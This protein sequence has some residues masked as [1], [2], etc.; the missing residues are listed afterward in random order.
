M[1]ISSSVRSS[2]RSP[3]GS[4]NVTESPQSSWTITKLQKELRQRNLSPVGRKAELVERLKVAVKEHGQSESSSSSNSL[5]SSPSKNRSTRNHQRAPESP[6]LKVLNSTKDTLTNSPL[7]KR[8][9]Q[10]VSEGFSSS[11]SSPSRSSSQRFPK[12]SSMVSN[13]L[14]FPLKTLFPMLFTDFSQIFSFVF[15]QFKEIV[16]FPVYFL[17]LLSGPK[18]NSFKKFSFSTLLEKEFLRRLTMFLTFMFSVFLFTVTFVPLNR[19]SK[20]PAMSNLVSNTQLAF[21][22]YRDCLVSGFYY[23]AI[24]AEHYLLSKRFVFLQSSFNLQSFVSKYL[25]TLQS[26]RGGLRDVPLWGPKALTCTF[27]GSNFLSHDRTPINWWFVV[28]NLSPALLA[29]SLGLSF[30]LFLVFVITNWTLYWAVREAREIGG[31][32]GRLPSW[33]LLARIMKFRNKRNGYFEMLLVALSCAFVPS[34]FAAL[35]CM[36]F[37]LFFELSNGQFFFSAL[38]GSFLFRSIAQSGLLMG[39]FRRSSIA[40]LLFSKVSL[41]I[42]SILAG[43]YSSSNSTWPFTVLSKGSSNIFI[44]I[45]VA[46]S[47]FMI[48]YTIRNKALLYQKSSSN[49]R[50]F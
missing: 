17:Q 31:V 42:P 48:I 3:S 8:I 24:V 33:S 5:T 18:R 41:P 39:P 47:A 45:F 23:N 12:G 49:R 43:Q 9:R 37:A 10:I 4:N 29:W 11:P 38:L 13:W 26:C 40:Q 15:S 6:I 16:S 27:N 34:I 32:G 21:N 50:N 7:A 35:L 46:I 20:M 28:A 22:F 44:N 25:M 19:F 30:G 2:N 1:P 36:S 14:N